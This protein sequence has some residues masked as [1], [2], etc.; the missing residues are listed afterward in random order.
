MAGFMP[1]IRLYIGQAMSCRVFTLVGCVT[2]TLS[3]HGSPPSGF[4]EDQT[5]MME[6]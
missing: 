5:R 1:L 4:V 3:R 2:V 6:D